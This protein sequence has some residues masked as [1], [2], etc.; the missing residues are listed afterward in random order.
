V[1]FDRHHAIVL[2]VIAVVAAAALVAARSSI[3]SDVMTAAPAKASIVDVP[4]AR[5]KTV[6]AAESAKTVPT[7]TP[8]ATPIA[9][10][11]NVSSVTL[12]GC[13]ELDQTTFRLKD[14]SGVDAP[15]AR[16]WKSG[17]FKKRRSSI[18]V[19]DETD[20]LTLRNYVG[21]RISAT[22]ILTNRELQAQSLQRIARSCS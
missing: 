1:P 9:A 17:F 14:A 8:A 13:L 18:D 19:V 5:T 6:V 22:G 2:G 12:T 21:Q 7:T 16:S 3:S 10:V 11:R 4:I 20:A 15:A